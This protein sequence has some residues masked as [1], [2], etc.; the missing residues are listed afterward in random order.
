MSSEPVR[1]GRPEL[2]DWLVVL[3][4][5][6]VAVALLHLAWEV[7]QLPLYTLWWDGAAHEIAFAVVHCTV[8]DVLIATTSLVTALAGYV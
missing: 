3:R 7:A 5:Y 2:A 8:G 1:I 6:L 4:R